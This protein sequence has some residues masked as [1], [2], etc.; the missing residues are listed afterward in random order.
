MVQEVASS[1]VHRASL[2]HLMM[3]LLLVV[4]SAAYWDF[5]W[6][7]RRQR[8]AVAIPGLLPSLRTLSVAPLGWPVETY[9][10]LGLRVI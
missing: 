6:E 9:S 10:F 2:V 1:Q 5:S 4:A 8:I 3:S 7:E